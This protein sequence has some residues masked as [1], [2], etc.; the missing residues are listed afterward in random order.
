MALLD[1]GCDLPF[2]VIGHVYPG[3]WNHA[4]DSS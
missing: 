1:L 2:P 3:G 4:E